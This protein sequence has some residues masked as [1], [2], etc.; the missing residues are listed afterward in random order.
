ML[1]NKEKFIG[2]GLTYD[3]VLLVP[4]YSENLPHEVNLGSKFTI[5]ILQRLKFPRKI[6]EKTALLVRNH[7]FVYGVDE[8]TEAGV[9]R[10]LRRVGLK[11]IDDLI[12]LRIADRLGSGVPKAVPYKL[13]H[14]KYLF[15]K[16]AQD[17]ISAKM[18][19][20]SGDDIMKILNIFVILL[21]LFIIGCSQNNTQLKDSS[22]EVDISQM[23]WQTTKKRLK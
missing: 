20:I 17:P 9:R 22:G 10:L 6:I 8:V 12:N 3:D 23:V 1:D 21:M 5:N 18:L 19:K 4:A 7:M 11:N 15:E 14:L 2:E 13:R 16:V